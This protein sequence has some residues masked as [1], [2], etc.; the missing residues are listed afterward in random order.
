MCTFLAI[1][2][3]EKVEGL[4]LYAFTITGMLRM[5]WI[6]WMDISWMAENYEFRWPGMAD[7][8]IPGVGLETGTGVLDQDPEAEVG[9]PD[10]ALGVQGQDHGLGVTAVAHAAALAADI[11]ERT[12]LGLVVWIVRKRAAFPKAALEVRAEIRMEKE[13]AKV[14]E[15]L[16]TEVILQQALAREMIFWKFREVPLEAAQEV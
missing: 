4:L 16:A 11:R 12:A 8:E 10:H 2:I 3:L 7:Q 5:Q 15:S 6:P 9:A 13:V 14:L 1:L